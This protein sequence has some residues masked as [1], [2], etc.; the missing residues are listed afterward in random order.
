MEKD[1]RDGGGTYMPELGIGQKKNIM[2]KIE[3]TKFQAARAV[4]AVSWHLVESSGHLRCV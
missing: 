4:L 1:R 2:A 3:I